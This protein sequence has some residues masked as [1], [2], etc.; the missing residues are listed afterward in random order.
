MP[1]R[2]LTGSRIRD[3]RISQGM[4]QVAL[5]RE[6]GISA[7]YLNLIE[8]NRR[9]I[10]G[11]LLLEI[12]RVLEVEPSQLSEG[13]EVALLEKLRHAALA[14][15]GVTVDAGRAE[16]LAGRFPDWAHLLADQ[17]Q[18]LE[19]LE[20]TVEALT[21]RLTHDPQLAASMHEVISVVTAI[22]STS[23][24]LVDGGD[25]DVEWQARFHRNLYE[26]SQRLAESSQALVAF[27]DGTGDGETE[28]GLTL[29]QEEVEKWLQG[30]GYVVDALEAG[31]AVADVLRGAGE[32]TGAATTESFARTYLERYRHDA[33]LMPLDDV[34][35]A[36]GEHGISPLEL[37]QVFEC[38]VPVVLRRIAIALAHQG[39][40]VGI[41]ACDSSGTLSFRKPLD[42]FPLPRFGAACPLWPLFQA[43][44]RPAVPIRSVVEQSGH[45]ARRFQTFAIAAPITV[46]VF[47]VAPVY[48]ATM[49]ILPDDVVDL[50]E[51]VI[52]TPIGFSCRICPRAGCKARREPSIL[53]DGF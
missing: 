35:R 38:A 4:R 12:S 19:G 13:A 16:E 1:K 10:G 37:A 29:P 39:Q 53:T 33:G 51:D 46:P 43:L 31:G 50:A 7:A 44:S 48:E 2:G 14:Q 52:A 36:I 23:A 32:L 45:I 20:R 25:I 8:H 27:L 42:G 34:I 21:D 26:D 5:A 11:K 40:A 47:D 49:L 41:V 17:Q 9:R 15:S 28:V 18:R 6:A 30:C 3:R 22:R 24:I